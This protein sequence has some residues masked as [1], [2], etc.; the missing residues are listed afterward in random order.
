MTNSL[1][2]RCEAV[3]DLGAV[4]SNI[5]ALKACH[6]RHAGN[7]EKPFLTLATVKANAYGHGD[8]EVAKAVE[9]SA[10]YYA[11]ACTAEGIA[12]REKGLT[13]PI[14]VLGPVFETDDEA[15]VSHE[16]TLTVFDKER[17]RKLDSCAERLGKTAK[18]HIAVDTGM[19]RIGLRPDDKGLETVREILA[20]RHLKT[21]GVFTHFATADEKDKKGADAALKKFLGFREACRADGICI[22]IWHCANTA[23]IIDGIGT[24]H[25]FDMIRCGIGLYGLYPSDE[26]IK[27]NV[28]LRP[29]LSWRSFLTLVKEIPQGTS[30]SYG[31]H[32]TADRD[33][34]IGTVCC[35]YADGYPRLLSSRGGE[36][37]IGGRRC[38]ILGNICMDQ[39]MVDLSGVPEAKAG[40]EVMLIGSQQS[41]DGQMSDTI[42]ADEIAAKCDTIS[43][44]IVC[45][46]SSRTRRRW[47]PC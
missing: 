12:L 31:Y 37:L 28:T 23:S 34:R 24:S 10:D 9:G 40:D 4:K 8:I 43:Y 20:L 11:V 5:E 42:T 45:G 30:V 1:H 14:L 7:Q 35:G 2:P 26:V 33:M 38:R 6:I 22:P 36:V 39:F 17:A 27:E 21:E 15:A 44:E 18:I 29:A 41:S 13:A 19:S 46:I 32:F 16:L 3:I 47:I 25:S